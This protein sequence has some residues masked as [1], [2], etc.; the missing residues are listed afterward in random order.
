MTD[1]KLFRWIDRN[2]LELGREM[3]LSYL[4]PLMVYLAAGIQGLTGI[5]GTFFVKEY[6]GL[7]AAFLAA[8]GFWAVIPWSIKMV[9]GHLVDLIWRWKSVLIFLG[10][11]LIA[12]SLLIMAGLIGN[13]AAMAAL[14]PV[15]SWFVIA[16]LLAPVGYVLQDAVA[17]AM[18]VEAVPR[19]DPDGIAIEPARRRLMHTTMQTLGRV[20]IIGGTVLVALINL[21]LFQG[22]EHLAQAEK[23]EIYRNVYLMALVIPVVSVAG[24]LIAGRLARRDRAR[25]LSKGL[26]LA[27]V[28]AL[29]ATRSEAPAANWWILGGGLL[30]VL[31]TLTMGLSKLEW[32]QEIIFFGS[33]AI[34]LFMMTRLVRELE[35]EARATL[36]GTAVVIFVFRAVPGPGPG[37]TWWM[38]DALGFD[39]AFLSVLSLIGSTLTLAGM[40]LFRRFMAERSITY[41]VG[42]LTVAG[43]LLGL[44]I[45]G[46]SFGFHEWTA[47]LTGGMVDAR[48]IALIDTALESPLGQIAM[49]PMLAWIANCAP[50]KLKATYFAVMAS[51]TNL[52]LSAS[53]LGTKYLNQIYDI[54]REVRDP[55]THAVASPADYS[56]LQPLLIS[57]IMLGLVLPFAAILAA[58]AMRLRSA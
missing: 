57:A 39:Q 55:L 3:R 13:R 43:F 51:F 15:E 58:R 5:V 33:L 53:Q 12:A 18:T 20:A 37:V 8:L 29:L 49:I 14:L 7:S 44:P 54:R 22:S 56:D 52:A 28:D 45:L 23:V 46:M 2:I 26:S 30:F 4:P 9:I 19:V 50:D 36:I 31:F 35:P 41:V 17:D 40:F 1:K 38:I 10:A 47:R 42:F 11:A 16:T 32:N 34:V 6:L 25:L 27:E 24:V 21:L 48:F